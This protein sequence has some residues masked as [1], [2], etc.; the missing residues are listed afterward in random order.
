[1]DNSR[2]SALEELAELVGRADADLNPTLL[3]ALTEFYVSK[4]SHAREEERQ[5]TELAMRLLDVV[6]VAHRRR[7]ADQLAGYAPAPRPLVQRLARD[8]IMVAEPILRRSP[9]LS[10]ADLLAIAREKGWRHAAAIAARKDFA[11][12]AQAAE[13]AS[14]V[15]RPAGTAT[16]E[17]LNELFF[18]A[19]AAERRLILEYLHYAPIAPARPVAPQLARERGLHLQAAALNRNGE[20]FTRSLAHALAVSRRQ[21]WRIA[22]DELGEPI[23]VAAKALAVPGEML[24]RILLCLHPAISRSVARVCEL[25]ALHEELR[26]ES[27]LRLLAIWQ[28]L[29]HA[30]RPGHQP[31]YAQHGDDAGRARSSAAPRQG[32]RTEA[33]ATKHGSLQA[34]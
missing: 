30:R 32:A 24:Q 26:P 16:A 17:E 3:R 12:S 1:M 33:R 19:D 2:S 28:A 14:N 27:A 4:Q 10:H 8:E 5:Y 15:T 11:Q 25:A 20:A 21:A 18:A 6:D 29:G 34:S 7:L 13:L 23:V 31:H 22:S 9:C